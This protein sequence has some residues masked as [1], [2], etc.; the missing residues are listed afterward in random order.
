M[1][2]TVR[3]IVTDH[4]D[5]YAHTHRLPAHVH[6]AARLLGAC[7]TA[8]L[9]GHVQACPDGHMQR[10]VH[11]S[12]RHRLCPQCNA[13]P[14]ARWLAKMRARLIGC[15]H[16][17]II[18]TIPRE[19]LGLWRYNQAWFVQALFRA[20]ADTLH[21]LCG[22]A[23]YLGAEAGFTLA[24]HTW[25]RALLLHPH[26]HALVTDGGLDDS[27]IWRTPR[28]R[29]FLPAH[30]VMALFRGKLLARLRTAL[31]GN[32]LR[33]PPDTSSQPVRNLINRLG[34]TKWNVHLC[35][36]YAHGEGVMIYLGRYVRGGPLKNSQLLDV[37]DTIR[38]TYHGHPA[39][40]ADCARTRQ[41]LS[42]SADGFLAR[43]LQHAP[44]PVHPIVRHY[45]LYATRRHSALD[46]ARAA[47]AQAP[48]AAAV[49]T[50]LTAVAY[51]EDRAGGPGPATHCPHC[52]APLVIR[53]RL[54]PQ[55][56]PP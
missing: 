15:A 12:C 17:H 19:L 11:H 51:Y 24:L 10:V 48:L 35:Q 44:L 56:G 29:C 13:V 26:I 27:G 32:A 20:V 28:K 41:T 42:L 33:L 4:F 47:H 52:G 21:A 40:R 22:D 55:R 6:R 5:S 36:R 9:G 18:F 3:T 8:K 38:L 45:G 34:R 30:V 53:A 49:P 7:R 14:T 54:Y 2:R 16:H 31:D 50:P 46:Q 37:G 39:D 1:E 25:T 43:Y 23:R